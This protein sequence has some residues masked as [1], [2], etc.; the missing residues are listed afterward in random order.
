M[1]AIDLFVAPAPLHV[2]SLLIDREMNLGGPLLLRERKPL[3]TLS[4]VA[5]KPSFADS[6]TFTFT[7][8]QNE[9]KTGEEGTAPLPLAA[10]IDPSEA[11]SPVPTDRRAG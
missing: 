10:P 7:A 1:H 11:R 3:G 4:D 5:A 6:L 9:A 2:F 8:A